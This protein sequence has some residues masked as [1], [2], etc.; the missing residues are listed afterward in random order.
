MSGA[1]KPRLEQL[2]A[3]VQVL[4]GGDDALLKA[5]LRAA[6]DLLPQRDDAVVERE[7]DGQAID[8]G[9]IGLRSSGPGLW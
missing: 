9:Q 5:R 3:P 8:R 1:G 4:G 6:L 7:R 2:G